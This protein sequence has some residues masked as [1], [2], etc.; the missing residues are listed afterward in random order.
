MFVDTLKHISYKKLPFPYIPC[1]VQDKKRGWSS[2]LLSTL[3][4]HTTTFKNISLFK[5]HIMILH[6]L[7]H[8]CH[9]H[10]S[11]FHTPHFSNNIF[12]SC[13]P[14]P[15]LPKFLLTFWDIISIIQ[16]SYLTDAYPFKANNHLFPPQQEPTNSGLF[17]TIPEDFY[18]KIGNT[19]L[20]YFY[21]SII[22]VAVILLSNFHC[23]LICLLFHVYV[24]NYRSL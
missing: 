10:P 22:S 21:P 3:E 9:S 2:L 19:T 12:V 4:N 15:P 8:C 7:F 5:V 13:S 24:S 20:W 23:F 6:L 14:F 18:S 16:H 17:W 11:L 1:W